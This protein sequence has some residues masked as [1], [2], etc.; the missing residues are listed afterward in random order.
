MKLIIFTGISKGFKSFLWIVEIVVPVSFLVA[1]FQW[2]GWLDQLYPFLNPLM[3]LLNLPA[4]A[5]LPIILGMLLNIY[6]V[7]AIL[8]V[9]PFSMGQMTLIAVFSLIAHNLIMEGIVQHR[10]GLNVVKTTLIRIAAAIFTILIISWF[11]GDLRQDITIQMTPLVAHINIT[12]GLVTWF[13]NTIILLAKMFGI[14]MFIMIG[15]EIS[16]ASGWI[17]RL[18]VIVKPVMRIL[19]LSDRTA[20]GCIAG[21][22]FG[23][24]YGGA[25]IIEECKQGILTRDEVERLHISLGINH[26][27]I[28]DPVLFAMLGINLLWLWIPRL[29][30]AIIAV[31]LYNLSIARRINP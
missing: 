5:A 18:I 30:T 19:G 7:I 6:A 29:I 9:I 16:R 13:T 2:T 24:L 11:F 23:L 17:D 3:N 20:L 15:L 4:Q 26:S 22:V 10:S 1:L 8:A 27:I 28:E 21:L 14:I 12:D 31:Q 25:V